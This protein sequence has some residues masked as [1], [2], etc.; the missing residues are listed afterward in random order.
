MLANAQQQPN[1]GGE[2]SIWKTERGTIRPRV[3]SKTRACSAIKARHSNGWT[4]GGVTDA[5]IG[6]GAGATVVDAFA[7]PGLKLDAPGCPVG[8]FE[9]ACCVA[10]AG[11]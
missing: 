5:L 1:P 6:T 2:K 7:C 11:L 4:G 10:C 8:G 3:R 9:D